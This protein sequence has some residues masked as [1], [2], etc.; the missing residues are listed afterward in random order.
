[1]QGTAGRIVY[2]TLRN[3]GV[4]CIFGMEDPIHVFHAVDRQATRIVTFHDER[5]GAI[6]DEGMEFSRAGSYVAAERLAA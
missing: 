1:M 5:H 6:A 2:E 4:T 3:Y